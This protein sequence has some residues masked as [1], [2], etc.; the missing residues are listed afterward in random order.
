MFG[1]IPNEQ[2]TDHRYIY[3]IRHRYYHS[4]H[5][6]ANEE[7]SD[8]KSEKRHEPNDSDHQR[9]GSKGL[10]SR[11]KLKTKEGITNPLF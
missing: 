5:S 7:L 11:T 9:R 10:C 1:I 4:I 2:E 8:R 3:L 6:R